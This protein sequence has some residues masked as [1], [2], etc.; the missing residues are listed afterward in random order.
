M[1]SS[2]RKSLY[3][4]FRVSFAVNLLVFLSFVFAV[5]YYKKRVNILESSLAR[6]MVDNSRLSLEVERSIYSM[7]N[8]FSLA[9][10]S[11]VSNS[12]S[13]SVLPSSSSSPFSR[14]DVVSRSSDE[15]KLP[16]FDF[17]GYCEADGVSFIR[18]GNKLFKSG[19]LLLGYP[20]QDITPDVV[21]YRD[22]FFKVRGS[23][24]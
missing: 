20:L 17:W 15:L 8:T 23:T 2:I 10:A 16:P 5:F 4:S 22:N 1:S 9:A 21:Q 19:D 13:R 7:T 3:N 11:F 12:L 24:P 18:L 6:L 14:S